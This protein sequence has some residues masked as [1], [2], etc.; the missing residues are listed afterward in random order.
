MPSPIVNTT[1]QSCVLNATSNIIAQFLTAY[2]SSASY[3]INWIPVL[4]FT[5]FNALNCPPNFLW[6]SFLESSFP[7]TYLVP[8]DSAI[9]A[10]AKNDEKELDREESTHTLLESKLSI[11]NTLI[12]FLLDQTIGATVNTLLFSL[13]FA[14]FRG[15][16]YKEAVGIAAEEFWPLMRAGWTVW[17]L[18]SLLNYSVVKS[19]EG[20]ALVGSLAGMGW[21]VYLSLVQ[22]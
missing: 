9:A 21:G 18:V 15:E 1:I 4:Q 14:G 19:V 3:T 2:R 13:V 8:S 10:A 6:Q 17:P 22:S 7:S 5:L 20:R 16:G 12:K 11:R